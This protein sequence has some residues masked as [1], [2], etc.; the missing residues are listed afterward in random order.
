MSR[1]ANGE[2]S[3][4]R[5]T[6]GRFA[7]SVY[8]HSPDGSRRRIHFY[9]HT[10]QEVQSALTKK[11]HDDE[12]G[13]PTPDANWTVE[14]FLD[15]WLNTVAPARI[16]AR[17][18]ESY[19]GIVR[20]H[21]RPFIGKK[22]LSRLTVADVQGLINIL[23]QQGKS[24]SILHNVRKVLSAALSRAEREQLVM[25][26]VARLVDLPREER[27][28][29][30]PWSIDE[31]N[32]FLDSIQGHRWQLGY[33]LLIYYGMRRG[34]VLG[35]RWSDIDFERESL[36]VNQQLQRIGRDLEV[37]PVKTA[38]GR[39][40]LPLLPVIKEALLNITDASGIDPASVDPDLPW[41][42]QLILL[43]AVGTPVD[44][45]NFTRDFHILREQAG[46]RRI[47]VH[48]IRHTAATLLKRLG[49]PARDAQA[50][51]GH[52]SVITTQSIYQHADPD[53][54][55][56]A[57]QRIESALGGIEHDRAGVAPE[58]ISDSN[59]LLSALLSNDS[60]AI[61]F[62]AVSPMKNAD[63]TGVKSAEFIGGPGGD[64]TLDTLLKR[65]LKT[66]HFALPTPVLLAIDN[67][68]ICTVF[69]HVAVR[70]A[71]KSRLGRTT[72]A[73]LITLRKAIQNARHDA[74]VAKMRRLSFPLNL[75]PTIGNSLEVRP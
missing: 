23:M 52:A 74:E 51:L 18:R 41:Q 36:S 17:T 48:H 44:P 53:L 1:R 9:G 66:P 13:V 71:V 21:I 12:A 59:A 11:L 10:R 56:D 34:E 2:G 62:E 38:A 22:I 3:I 43:S 33:M 67:R 39:R 60:H 8:V 73:E 72:L 6:D 61:K 63:S 46:L 16:R 30:K 75:L 42:K 32:V 57:L 65:L 20:V 70:S 55:R 64:R 69:G 24:P 31:A 58:A 14:G 15:Y 35:L 26:N 7:A 28:E 49:V 54:H 40:R 27:K 45:H 50:I 5:R 68:C 19:E 29:I 25:R 4:Y 47:T 37:G